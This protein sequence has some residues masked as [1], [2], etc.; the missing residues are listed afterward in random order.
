MAASLEARSHLPGSSVAA[1]QDFL[2]TV[3]R[4]LVNRPLCAVGLGGRSSGRGVEHRIC[5]CCAAV[6]GVSRSSAGGVVGTAVPLL[7]AVPDEGLE[8]TAGRQHV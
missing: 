5:E 2:M 1:D 7:G 8:G 6:C 4:D 3:K